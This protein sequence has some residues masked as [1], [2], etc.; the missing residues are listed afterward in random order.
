MTEYQKALRAE[1]K[2]RHAKRLIKERSD[3]WLRKDAD[4]VLR[5]WKVI[6]KKRRK[7]K[8]NQKR[9]GKTHKAT[10]ISGNV[11]FVCGKEWYFGIKS[12]FSLTDVSCEKCLQRIRAARFKA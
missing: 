3:N 2:K 11:K 1:A 9:T 10:M 5:P 8:E 7:Q 12:S 6:K 4:G